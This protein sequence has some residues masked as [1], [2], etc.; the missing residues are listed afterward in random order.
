MKALLGMYHA[1]TGRA[2]T[3]VINTEMLGISSIVNEKWNLELPVLTS[4]DRD[5]VLTGEKSI[6][7]PRFGKTSLG[8]P[9]AHLV[10]FKF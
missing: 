10:S 1:F 5:C 4:D 7:P 2:F 6:S 8:S 3:V 9:Y